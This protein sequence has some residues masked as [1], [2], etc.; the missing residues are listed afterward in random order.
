MFNKI[1]LMKSKEKVTKIF[2]KSVKKRTEKFTEKKF[3]VLK[4]NLEKYAIKLGN[5]R[6]KNPLLF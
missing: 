4:R 3:R 2:L 6:Q 5:Q 1:S